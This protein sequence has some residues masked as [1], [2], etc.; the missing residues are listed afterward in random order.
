MIHC[1]MCVVHV[2]SCSMGDPWQ[3]FQ[4]V[5]VMFLFLMVFAHGH[6]QWPRWESLSN[7]SPQR[8]SRDVPGCSTGS[9]WL[10]IGDAKMPSLLRHQTSGPRM[11][12]MEGFQQICY[13]FDIQ[14]WCVA[15]VCE[16]A[17]HRGI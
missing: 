16:L 10:K 1:E 7:R 14:I 13:G 6:C 4:I 8:P 2:Q 15:V 9:G 5:H 11:F 17:L 3:P 12:R